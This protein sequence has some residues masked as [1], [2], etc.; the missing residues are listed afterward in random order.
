MPGEAGELNLSFD[1]RVNLQTGTGSGDADDP[2]YPEWNIHY[3]I[4]AATKTKLKGKEHR[5]AMTGVVT[6]ATSPEM[7]GLPVRIL[8]ETARRDYWRLPLLSVNLPLG[9]R[10]WLSLPS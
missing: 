10:D 9:E 5:Y 4:D 6:H 2:V 3:A 8:A 7:I 1:L